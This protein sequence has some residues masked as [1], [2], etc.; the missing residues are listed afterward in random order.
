M[1]L[2]IPCLLHCLPGDSSLG[3]AN[4]LFSAFPLRPLTPPP[5]VFLLSPPSPLPSPGDSW[6]LEDR[7]HSWVLAIWTLFHS[8][9]Q[10]LTKVRASLEP[11]GN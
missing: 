11:G 8:G 2:G 6:R 10:P 3:N 5:P 9:P 1:V 7:E 4:L